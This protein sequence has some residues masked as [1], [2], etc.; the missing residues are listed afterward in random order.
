MHRSVS[1]R[2][3]LRS[4]MR[5]AEPEVRIHSPPAESQERTCVLCIKDVDPPPHVVGLEPVPRGFALLR[6]PAKPSLLHVEL[7]KLVSGI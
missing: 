4:V 2:P 5:I 7:G 6:L 1:A 3:V